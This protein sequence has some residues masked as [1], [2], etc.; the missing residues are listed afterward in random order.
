[1]DLKELDSTGVE[2][3]SHWY[4][5]SKGRALI[6]LI[7]DRR[8]DELVDVGAGS[9]VFSRLLLEQG[10]CDRALCIDSNYQGDSDAVHHG[11]PLLLRRELNG[12][13]GSAV[14]MMDVLEHV[15]DDAELLQQYT[16]RLPAGGIVVVTVP[17]F[18]FLWSGHDVLLEHYRRYRISDVETL[19]RRA[20]LEIVEGRYFF[21]LLFP[22]AAAMRLLDRI[23][24]LFM[25]RP[26]TSALKRA[27]GW[28]NSLLIKLH[29][30]ERV[31]VFKVN[32]LAGVSVLVLARKT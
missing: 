16:D 19:L 21:G 31:S 32:R 10:I 3:A 15:A 14:L 4:Y 7:G 28:L 24:V 8:F 27:P 9:G 6:D 1:M 23:L 25:N 29:D 12:H 2:P 26:K 11:K 18:Q 5:V 22:V 17:A 30:F 13:S 20:G